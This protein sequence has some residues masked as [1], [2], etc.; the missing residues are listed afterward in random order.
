MIDTASLM[1]NFIQ[2]LQHC[3]GQRLQFAG[4]QG[5]C[6]RGEATPSSDIDVVVL[7][8]TISA[9]DLTQYKHIMADLPDRARLC[10]FVGGMDTLEKWDKGE[11]VSFCFDTVPYYGSLDS[12]QSSLTVDDGRR[13]LH[14]GACGL[15]HGCAHNYCHAQNTDALREMQKSLFFLLR[16][17]HYCNTGIFVTRRGDLLPLLSDI[18]RGLLLDNVTNFEELSA[19][20]LNWAAEIIKADLGNGN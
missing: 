10:G 14:M 7:L 13:A 1:A 11:L 20:L 17:K 15:Y 4:L 8:D 18:E 12:I 3:F 2:R 16:L 19:A 6:A 5:S 9:A